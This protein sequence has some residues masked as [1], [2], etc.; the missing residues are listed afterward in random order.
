MEGERAKY[1]MREDNGEAHEVS[2]RESLEAGMASKGL[3]LKGSQYGYY[4]Q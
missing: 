4:D 3:A 1:P 2:D